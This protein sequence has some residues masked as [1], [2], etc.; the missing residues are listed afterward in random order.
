[1]RR[2][3]STFLT[4]VN[5]RR[6]SC[7]V[8]GFTMIELLITLV[9]FG[10]LLSIAVPALSGWLDN[11][12]LK[13]GARTMASDVAFLRESALASGRT[14]LMTFDLGANEYTLRWDSDGAGTYAVVPNY[15]ALR[16]L[17][18][19][20][21]GVRITSASQSTISFTSRGSINNLGTVVITNNRGS[22]ATITTMITGRSHVTYSMQ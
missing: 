16:R 10:I 1:M 11:S 17:S 4:G 12:N 6:H 7:P 2:I 20:G 21:S 18:D 14:H 15:P 3:R 9:F 19:S 13:A 5:T 8:A 22:T